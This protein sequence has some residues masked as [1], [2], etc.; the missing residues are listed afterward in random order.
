MKKSII[1]KLSFSKETVADL[2]SQ[3]LKEAKGGNIP[4]TTDCV[5]TWDTCAV[6]C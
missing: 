4:W 3:E 1:K 6:Y 5:R 2:N